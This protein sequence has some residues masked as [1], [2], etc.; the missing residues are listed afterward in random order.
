MQINQGLY[1]KG[2]IFHIFN[3]SIAHFNIFGNLVDSQRFIN[4]LDY[5]NN[6]KIDTSFSK[7]I[8]KEKDFFCPNL[9]Y[10]KNY[11]IV[12]YLAYVVMPDHYHL[13][14]KVLNDKYFIRFISNVENSFT[15]YFNL[16]YNRKGPLWQSSFKSVLIKDNEQLLHTTR[17]I[18]LNPTSAELVEKP[19]D[20]QHNSYKYYLDDNILK[21]YLKEIS[22]R[23]A[24]DYQKFVE[25]RKDYQTKLQIIKKITLE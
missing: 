5:Y 13:L 23:N 21:N 18:H 25:D 24:K 20:W 7:F 1:P 10:H 14:L 8:E 22:I 9:L 16:K 12:K 17:Y 15:R 6:T 19:I 4:T 2:E 3:K 11:K